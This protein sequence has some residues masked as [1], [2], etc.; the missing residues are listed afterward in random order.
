MADVVHYGGV[1]CAGLFAEDLDDVEVLLGLDDAATAG[2][3]EGDVGE[4]G[5][6]SFAGHPAEDAVCFCVGV[7]GELSCNCAEIGA[8]IERLLGQDCV[9]LGTAFDVEEVDLLRL[10]RQRCSELSAH[11]VLDD[12]R[13]DDGEVII[14]WEVDPAKLTAEERGE[15][16]PSDCRVEVEVVA[17]A[18]VELSFAD[19]D[20]VLAA[21]DA[22]EFF[23]LDSGYRGGEAVGGVL[24]VKAALRNVRLDALFEVG[25]GVLMFADLEDDVAAGRDAVGVVAVSDEEHGKHD[26][27]ADPRNNQDAV[28]SFGVDFVACEQVRE[29]ACEAAQTGEPPFRGISLILGSG[30]V[31]NQERVGKAPVSWMCCAVKGSRATCRAR[32]SASVSMR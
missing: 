13:F 10:R 29:R 18:V 9:G 19:G 4:L 25:V 26:N 31:A 2:D 17:D 20:A 28:A 15:L 24:E 11:F 14:E 5:V 16:V 12:P 21:D 23:A 1:D 8:F 22:V 32:L 3:A 6:E 30:L 7:L 27:Q